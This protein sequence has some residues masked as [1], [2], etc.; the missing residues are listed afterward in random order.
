MPFIIGYIVLI[1]LITVF[2][3][4]ATWLPGMTV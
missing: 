2:P 3:C 1:I 4:L